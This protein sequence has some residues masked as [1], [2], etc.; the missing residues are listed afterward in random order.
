MFSTTLTSGGVAS[1]SRICASTSLGVISA[2]NARRTS[3]WALRSAVICAPSQI[4]QSFRPMVSAYS[5][6][7][8]PILA[9]PP[10]PGTPD[11]GTLVEMIR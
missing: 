9:L 6:I 11:R 1:R 7:S 2:A 4:A 8:L 3:G 5:P 10:V